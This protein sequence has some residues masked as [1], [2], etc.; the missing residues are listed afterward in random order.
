MNNPSERKQ[1]IILLPSDWRFPGYDHFSFKH[2]GQLARTI[3]TLKTY[4]TETIRKMADIA[5]VQPDEVE[6]FLRLEGVTSIEQSVKLSGCSSLAV[7][8][9]HIFGQTLSDKEALEIVNKAGFDYERIPQV[10]YD[11]FNL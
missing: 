7:E 8:T 3:L 9:A 5:Q 10:V 11:Y 6:G 1:R 2:R 4:Q